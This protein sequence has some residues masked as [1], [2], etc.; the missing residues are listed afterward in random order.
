MGGIVRVNAHMVGCKG[1]TLI[2]DVSGPDIKPWF[3]VEYEFIGGQTGAFY[4][5]DARLFYEASWSW[6]RKIWERDTT[7]YKYLTKSDRGLLK[8]AIERYVTEVGQS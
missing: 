6:Q 7:S 3:V 2:D 5:K 8:Q 1:I 4:T